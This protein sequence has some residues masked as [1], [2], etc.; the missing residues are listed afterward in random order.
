MRFRLLASVLSSLFL[1]FATYGRLHAQPVGGKTGDSLS[2]TILLDLSYS[3][4]LPLSLNK[5]DVHGSTRL[6]EA[7]RLLSALIETRSEAT[8]WSLLTFGGAASEVSGKAVAVREGFT[9]DADKLKAIVRGLSSWGVTPLGRAMLVAERYSGRHAPSANR[10]L[11]VVSDGIDTVP[12]LF[13]LPSPGSLREPSTRI[14]FAGF[15]LTDQRSL[16][17][18]LVKWVREAGGRYVRAANPFGVEAALN[19][20]AAPT[21]L[22]AGSAAIGTT[23]GV[24]GGGERVSGGIRPA[25]F[26]VLALIPVPLVLLMLRKRRRKLLVSRA[27]AL[28]T[29]RVVLSFTREGGGR[30]EEIE[31]EELPAR[32]TPGG[33]RRAVAPT[34]DIQ[35]ARVVLAAQAPVLVNGVGVR[36]ASLDVGDR[37]RTSGGLWIFRGAATHVSGPA[38]P[39]E[40]R[41]IPY[42]VATSLLAIGS[43]VAVMVFIF[44]TSTGTNRR[45]VSPTPAATRATAP[46]PAVVVEP[47]VH[48]R[49]VS[50]GTKPDFFKADIMFIHAHPD[51]ESIDFGGLMALEAR[52]GKRIVTVLFTDGT[53]GLDQYPNRRVGGI[54]P[55]H[56]LRGSALAA[57]R[58]QEAES[59]LSILGSKAYVRLGL[60]NNPY[61]SIREILPLNEVL[62]R[63]GGD[64][65]VVR[66][67]ID[68]LEGYRPEIVVSPDKHHRGVFKHFEHEAVGYVTDQ[69]LGY[70]RAHGEHFVRAHL[71]AVDPMLTGEYKGVFG[72]D[73]MAIDPRSGLTYRAIQVA[74]LKKHATQRDASVVGVEVVPNFADEY[75]V[76]RSWAL[77]TPPDRYFSPSPA[78][79]G[80]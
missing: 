17:A 59:A 42:Y 30:S 16:A 51:D 34:V 69:A 75:Y 37:I 7:K 77:P 29:R 56:T 20:S 26:F 55:A 68:L 79:A 9:D 35:E 21:S 40:L 47:F 73:V 6:E 18:S 76:A 52:S 33:G 27:E 10:V 39:P 63:W 80:G 65:H 78:R 14:L 41:S 46:P 62:R 50:P 15:T 22:A 72:V 38:D 58:V 57:V 13:D 24:T 53:A 49:M 36:H 3:M 61:D 2:V 31:L 5:D 54:Y 19:S 44:S 71:I 12:S 32:L 67:L 48:T 23:T 60:L 1:L 66:E 43:L 25:L 45:E 11:L 4:R 8:K 64:A 74:A 70:L 28:R